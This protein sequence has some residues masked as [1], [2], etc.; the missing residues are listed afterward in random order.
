MVQEAIEDWLKVVSHQQNT[1]IRDGLHRLNIL[2]ATALT[3]SGHVAFQQ[4]YNAKSLRVRESMHWRT[5]VA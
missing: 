3:E 4:V 1:Q 5:R 2:Q